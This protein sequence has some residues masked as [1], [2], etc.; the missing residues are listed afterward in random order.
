MKR[1]V[2][3]LALA[4]AAPLAAQTKPATQ[5][6]IDSATASIKAAQSTLATASATL[7]A[8]GPARIDTVRVLR[9]DTLILIRHD[10]V[11]LAPAPAPVPAVDT[12]PKIPP[13]TS[14]PGVTIL[15]SDSFESGNLSAKQNGVSWISSAYVDVASTI[16]R[17]GSRAARF[18]QGTSKNWSELRFGG[19]PDLGEV[20]IQYYLY[21]PS[22]KE[23]PS[24]G[25]RVRVLGGYND[26]FFRL[27]G[28]GYEEADGI[29]VGAS[30]W[31]D[32]SKQDGQ[33]GTEYQYRPP[34]GAQWG[35]GQGIDGLTAPFVIDANRGRWIQMRIRATP[36][37]AANNDGVIQIWA[38]GRLILSQTSV[39]NYGGST[40]P[41][42]YTAG[43]LLGYAN[44][45]FPAGQVMYIDDVTISVGGFPP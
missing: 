36:A 34:S 35:M 45:G 44:N 6:Q 13:P 20:F 40:A 3:I 42:G 4:L 9:I 15:F 12:T 17:S 27:W 1:I 18:N 41:K 5:A 31:G 11:V 19:L 33:L 24:V 16:A 26:K 32:A 30:I 25:P 7:S 21:M 22:G 10:T 38:D 28:G 8:M 43:Y 37:T 39:H 23:S 2:S 29:K 14:D